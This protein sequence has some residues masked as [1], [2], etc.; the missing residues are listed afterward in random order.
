[1]PV[2]TESAMPTLQQ[3]TLSKQSASIA[4]V[5]G[6]TYTGNAYRTSLRSALDKAKA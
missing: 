1:V 2:V 5:S 3:E 6:A 4:T